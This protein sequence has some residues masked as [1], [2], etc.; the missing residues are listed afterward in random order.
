MA[1]GGRAAERPSRLDPG[2]TIGILGGGQLGRMIAIA[3]ARL[4]YRCHVFEP[5]P[6][7]PAAQVCARS[8]VA[9]YDDRAALDAFAAAVDVVTL[10]FE[11]VPEEPVR[12][13]A[14][15]V[16]VRPGP[17]VLAVAQDR[18][19]EKRFLNDIDVPTTPFA[20]VIDPASLEAAVAR[21]GRPAV[22][23]SARGG[24][25][26]KGQVA[27]RPETDLVQAWRE[28]GSDRGI[29]EG[30][31][32]FAMEISVIVA[33]GLHGDTAAYAPVE[34]RHVDHILDTT[35]APA[36]IAPGVAAQARSLASRTAEKLDVTGLLAVEMFVTWKGELLVNE[37][38]PRPHN[39][40]HWTIDGCAI[41]QFQQ[42]VRAICGL[43]LGSTER[44]SDA[45]MKNL[46]GDAVE[47][48]PAILA[49]PGARLHLYGKT[50]T[51]PGRKMGH[52]TRLRPRRD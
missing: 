43:P 34:N 5:A 39:S 48:W 19:I 51:R 45:E 44:H 14:E 36:A 8:T 15:R 50:E 10:E 26:G 2:S 42:L 33:H 20:E 18:L 46:I 28:M 30:W 21:I 4:G 12:Y 41:S 37:I 3:A 9:D 31:V 7:S 1:A 52:V 49:E 40:G 38:A 22:L 32:D 23:K 27:I 29:L 6:D 24:Y 11:N 47:T 17:Q 35:I 13:L 25:D 16:P